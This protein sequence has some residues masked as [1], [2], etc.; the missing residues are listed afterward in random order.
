MYTLSLLLV[1]FAVSLDGFGVGVTYGLRQLKIPV[2]SILV[3]ALCSAATVLLSMQLGAWLARFLA[4]SWA[5]AIGAFILIGIGI[6]SIWQVRRSH[7]DSRENESPQA[8]Q[9]QGVLNPVPARD[10]H[11]VATDPTASADQTKSANQSV[12]RIEMKRLGLVIQILKSPSAADVDKSGV[13]SAGEAAMLGLA[14]SLDSFG[15]GIGAAMLGFNP[16][17][18]A[19]AVS[20]F[21]ALFLAAGLHLGFRLSGIRL[22]HK[23]NW[24]PGLLLMVIG[25]YKLW[26]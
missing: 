17:L 26:L 21:G 5:E 4:T 2:R 23:L 9:K 13:I 15:A 20:L 7:E 12:L 25:I 10:A 24:V 3:I 11:T 19:A 16:W 1:A 18:T 6:F 22:M 14:L 8:G